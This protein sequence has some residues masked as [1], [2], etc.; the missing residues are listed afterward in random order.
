M[1]YHH[2]YHIP[3]TYRARIHSKELEDMRFLICFKMESDFYV[4]DIKSEQGHSLKFRSASFFDKEN[5]LSGI[6][7]VPL[8]CLDTIHIFEYP[9]ELDL[10]SPVT[11][12]KHLIDTYC[13]HQSIMH[14]LKTDIKNAKQIEELEQEALSQEN[15]TSDYDPFRYTSR[16]DKQ[17]DLDDTKLSVI[18][19]KDYEGIQNFQPFLLSKRGGKVLS[20]PASYTDPVTKENANI[21]IMGWYFLDKQLKISWKPKHTRK[22]RWRSSLLSIDIISGDYFFQ[23]E[24][25]K[26]RT[27]PVFLKHLNFKERVPKTYH[28]DV[29]QQFHR[30]IKLI[31]EQKRKAL[32]RRIQLSR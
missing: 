4:V 11:K 18:A 2:Y 1:P 29:E 22:R 27:A 32:L 28:T 12:L 19:S 15:I 10:I 3:L 17:I 6:A 5:L 14:Y 20:V 9:K 7:A 8:S 26:N 25:Y 24:V 23:G 16:T 31:D 30:L 21:E 13:H